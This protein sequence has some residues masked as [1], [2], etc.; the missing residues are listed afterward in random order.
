MRPTDR[1]AC[2]IHNN[3]I[4]TEYYVQ[5]F[6]FFCFFYSLIV[7]VSA[8]I[9]TNVY[10]CSLVSCLC[11]LIHDACMCAVKICVSYAK[12]KFSLNSFILRF[13]WFFSNTTLLIQKLNT[14]T[15]ILIVSIR[16][17]KWDL[18]WFESIIYNAIRSASLTDWLMM[19][20]TKNSLEHF[21][22]NKHTNHL[23]FK[24]YCCFCTVYIWY[25]I[26]HS[27]QRLVY[28]MEF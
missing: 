1:P 12:S 28:A 18:V 25:F 19:L 26:A 17:T 15:H 4:C 6:F 11:Q 13:F 20:R 8:R 27:S 23:Q 10:S 24:S 7:L 9:F 5:P 16:I 22:R 3:T 21:C 14:H 2:R